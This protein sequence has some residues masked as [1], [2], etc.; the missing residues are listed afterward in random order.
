[1]KKIIFIITPLIILITLILIPIKSN[2]SNAR[3]KIITEEEFEKIK[4][5]AENGEP[6]SQNKIGWFY[7]QGIVVNEN[8]QKA[9]E[10]YSK[11]ANQGF[12]KA[13]INLG[14]MNEIGRGTPQNFKKATIWYSLAKKQ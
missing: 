3:T 8:P 11:A 14:V 13:Q 9:V 5:L 2:K 12:S 7:D 1:M 4:K 10:W 6:S